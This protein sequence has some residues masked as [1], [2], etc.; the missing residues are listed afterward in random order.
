MK[1]I[2]LTIVTL[3]SFSLLALGACSGS[4]EASKSTAPDSKPAETT[5]ATTAQADSKA[6]GNP[7]EGEPHLHKGGED[8]SHGGSD[9]GIGGQVVETEDYHLEF[10]SNK[11]GEGVS[12]DFMIGESKSHAP[13]TTA[14]VTAQVQMPDGTQQSLDMKYDTASK[15]YKATLPKATAGE[16]NVAILSDI[17]GKKMNSRFSFKQ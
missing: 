1:I 7:K 16:Y 10:L 13:V 5:T 14:K 2:K 12:L 17:G 15:L 9:H 11:V 6:Q 8:H 4:S 3:S